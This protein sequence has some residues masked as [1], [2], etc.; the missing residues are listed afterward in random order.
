MP[1]RPPPTRYGLRV[2]GEDWCESTTR[3]LTRPVSSRT[4]RTPVFSPPSPLVPVLVLGQF[5]V[6]AL[7]LE[8]RKS[9]HTDATQFVVTASHLL[10]R[11][12]NGD[13]NIH[14]EAV[15]RFR[16]ALCDGGCTRQL[17]LHLPLHGLTAHNV[18]DVSP[19]RPPRRLKAG[20]ASPTYGGCQSRSFSRPCA[21]ACRMA[22]RRKLLIWKWRAG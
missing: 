20:C 8:P 15:G 1:M 11:L 12:P 13:K 14:G 19:H 5:I 22:L 4:S 16:F 9:T 17:P 21:G 7:V 3:M 2:R 10:R 18:G 6:I